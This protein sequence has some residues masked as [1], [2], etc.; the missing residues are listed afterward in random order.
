MPAMATISEIA[1]RLSKIQRRVPAR[2]VLAI[3]GD[4]GARRPSLQL[5]NLRQR[6]LHFVFNAHDAHQ[7]LHHI[8]QVALH[9]E[10]ILAGRAAFERLERFLGGSV[11]IRRD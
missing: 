2:V 10:R 5:G 4:T 7:L 1:S 6:L 8:L 3:P 9:R 11:N